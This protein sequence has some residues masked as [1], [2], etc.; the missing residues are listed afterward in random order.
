M[1]WAFDTA[2]VWALGS[3][4][5]RA[6]VVVEKSPVADRKMVCRNMAAGARRNTGIYEGQTQSGRKR[7]S[8]KVN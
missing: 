5:A 6:A 3:R 2:I 4:I 7:R 1:P 8:D